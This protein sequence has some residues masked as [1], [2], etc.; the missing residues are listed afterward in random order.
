MKEG[1]QIIKRWRKSSAKRSSREGG[2]YQPRI[3][4]GR[5]RVIN[6]EVK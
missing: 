5:E 2:N 3:Q 1:I 4:V 6:K